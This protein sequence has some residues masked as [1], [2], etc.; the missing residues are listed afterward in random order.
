VL[1]PSPTWVGILAVALGRATTPSDSRQNGP[2]RRARR[3]GGQ[4]SFVSLP[5]A[6]VGGI[7]CSAAGGSRASLPASTLPAIDVIKCGQRAR[8]GREDRKLRQVRNH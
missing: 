7:V 5:R 1:P 6:Q 2:R 4:A 8:A 3:I